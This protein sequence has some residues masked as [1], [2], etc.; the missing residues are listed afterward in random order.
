MSMQQKNPGLTFW[1]RKQQGMVA[2]RG[3]YESGKEGDICLVSV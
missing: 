1:C 3:E 2:G